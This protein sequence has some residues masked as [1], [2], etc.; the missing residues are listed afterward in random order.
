MNVEIRIKAAQFPFWNI[1]FKF[2]GPVSLQCSLWPE[3]AVRYGHVTYRPSL[4]KSRPPTPLSS[5]Y[6]CACAV[7]RAGSVL[8][9]LWPLWRRP[10]QT[11]PIKFSL[12]PP[13]FTFCRML[14]KA[15]SLWPF[16]SVLL[17]SPPIL[18]LYILDVFHIPA[19]IYNIFYDYNTDKTT[20]FLF[21]E[22]T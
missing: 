9:G 10:S 22:E 4:Y 18:C 14:C 8:C 12:P 11:E 7:P 13:P 6:S 19:A 21:C 15:S 3:Q 20:L 16:A 2:S 5:S 1:L 17:P